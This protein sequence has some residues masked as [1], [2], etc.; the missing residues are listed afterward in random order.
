MSLWIAGATM[1]LSVGGKVAAGLSTGK[2]D[3]QGAIDAATDISMAEK[4]QLGNELSAQRGIL[5]KK[6]E[7]LLDAATT[8][9]R[10][11]YFD[12]FKAKEGQGKTGFASTDAGSAEI[13]RAE[14]GVYEQY[15]Q[16]AE[17]I[18]DDIMGQKTSIDLNKQ[19]ELA[20]I[21]KRMQSNIDSVLATPDTFMEGFMGA[22]DY[23]VG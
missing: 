11:S 17:G 16:K 1:A 18:R 2:V 15:K 6:Q 8:Q 3:S 5:D 7:N 22:S 13:R 4:S 9:S 12:I 23:E 21:E 19:K 14:S 10:S 20:T